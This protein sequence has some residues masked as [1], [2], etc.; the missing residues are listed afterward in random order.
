MIIV[1]KQK[2]TKFLR[3]LLARRKLIAG[4]VLAVFLISNLGVYGWYRNRT[5]PGTMVNGRKLGNIA[6]AQLSGRLDQSDLLPAD[7]QLKYKDKSSELSTRDLGITVDMEGLTTSLKRQR[8]W[9]PIANLIRHP[10]VPL[11]LKVDDPR[12]SEQFTKLAQTYKLDPVNASIVVEAGRFVIK[13]EAEGYQ[14]EAATVKAAVVDK[15]SKG[16][17]SIELPAS[18]ISP[19]QKQT[20]LQ[21]GLQTLQAQQDTAIT[22]TYQGKSKKLTPAELA[23]WFTPSGSSYA[24]A[25]EKIKAS[26]TA[27]GTSFG[28]K[29]QNLDPAT[30]SAKDAVQNIKPLTLA[31]VAMPIAQKT[32][33]YCTALRGVDAN[34]LGGLQAKLQTTYDDSR[35]WSLGGQVLMT[36]AESGCSFTVWLSAANQMA[37]FGAICDAD[38]SCRVGANVVINFDRWQGASTA[39]NQAGGSLD[40]YRS[41]V[42]NHE[43][44]HWFGFEHA[45]CSGPGQPAAVMQ[46]QSISLGGCTFN[47][48]PLSS[49]LTALKNSLGI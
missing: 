12:F 27:V 28:I 18:T 5:Y 25:D 47:P 21:A 4:I 6:Y 37:T 23:D 14:L 33:T 36:R 15:L 8:S 9:L 22:L 49:E 45:S 16:N 19:Q 42:I 7:I 48:W 39:W 11:Q 31:L 20:D 30:A 3:P 34:Y 38:W 41:M 44:G 2:L 35:G 24:L 13:H 40:N 29:V 26:I 43:T 46:Q 1:N 32:Y 17:T 10:A